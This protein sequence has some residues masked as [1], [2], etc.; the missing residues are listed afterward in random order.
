MAKY[1]LA[2]ALVGLVMGGF[3]PAAAQPDTAAPAGAFE[4]NAMH[5]RDAKARLLGKL[6]ATRLSAHFEAASADEAFR[7]LSRAIGCPIKVHFDDEDGASSLRADAAVRLLAADVDALLVLEMLIDQCALYEPCTWQ[8]RNG[9]I[10]VGTKERLGRRSATETRMYHARDLALEPPYFARIGETLSTA[11]FWENPYHT[12][13]LSVPGQRKRAEEAIDE[14]VRGVVELIEPG[15]WDYGQYDAYLEAVRKEDDARGRMVARPPPRIARLRVWRDRI[16]IRAPDYIHRQV[17]GYPPAVAPDPPTEEERIA[18]S[19][20][21]STPRCRLTVRG[22]GAEP[23]RERKT[24]RLSALDLAGD[25][26]RQRLAAALLSRNVD[27]NLNATPARQAIASFSEIIGAPIVGRYSDDKLGYGIDPTRPI[28]AQL[29]QAPAVDA[30]KEILGQCEAP[31]GPCTWQIRRGFIEVGTKTRLSVPAARELRTYYIGDLILDIPRF[32]A[33][34]DIQ[35]R[36]RREELALGVVEEIVENIEPGAWDYGQ[37]DYYPPETIEAEL[38]P[39]RH[40]GR[41]TSSPDGEPSGEPGTPARAR[42][43]QPRYVKPMKT[44]I[45][46]Y[47]RDLLIIQAPGYIHRQIGGWGAERPASDRS[48]VGTDGGPSS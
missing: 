35:L 38:R 1:P 9:F 3:E 14:I 10:E 46:R 2:V 7:C 27:L 11:G 19:R 17:G 20:A 31:A 48:A 13:A 41:K 30:L 25:P 39:T 34:G 5:E 44:A 16:M 18:R 23:D 28:T 36:K 43:P 24:R 12:A 26:M 32:I 40:D 47:W 42:T 29:A 37:I 4:P 8:L 33:A 22:I 21:A 45:I 6:T 15:N